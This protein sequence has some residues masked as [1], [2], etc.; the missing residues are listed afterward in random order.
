MRSYLVG[1]VITTVCVLIPKPA[2]AF[3]GT[4]LAP[5]F[6]LVSGQVSEITK[7]TEIIGMAKD[8]AEALRVLNEGISKAVSQI[9]TLQAIVER[10]QGLDPTGV[11]SLADLNNLLTKAQGTQMLIEEMLAIKVGIADQAIERSALQSD[12]SYKMGQE[13]VVTGSQLAAESQQASPGRA[14][15]ITAAASSAQM[16]S[17]GVELQTLSQLV[18][19]QAMS[20]DFQKSQVER[21]IQGDTLRRGQYQ[22]QLA[23]R[24][25]KPRS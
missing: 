18:E 21:E 7:L 22:R 24:A 16:L 23:L 20:L 14:S 8:Q 5:L 13:M 6:Q 25:R 11:K 19:L 15:Q 4:E 9:Q 10:T 2:H 12:T 3:F 17:Q 1:L